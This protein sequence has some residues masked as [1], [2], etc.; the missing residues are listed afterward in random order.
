MGSAEGG[1]KVVQ[2][3]V[4]SQ[5]DGR[6]ASTPFVPLGVE[7]VVMPDGEVEEIPRGD[8]G[9]ILVVVLGIDSRHADEVGPKL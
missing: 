4:V 1:K 7:K 2:R 5:I 9:R 3:E 6:Q 8:A